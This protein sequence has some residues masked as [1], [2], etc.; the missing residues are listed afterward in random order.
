MNLSDV[1]LLN[2]PHLKEQLAYK[3]L[4]A[5]VYTLECLRDFL[6]ERLDFLTVFITSANCFVGCGNI[7]GVQT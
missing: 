7:W 1:G 5:L 4:L 2:R 6:K 3:L